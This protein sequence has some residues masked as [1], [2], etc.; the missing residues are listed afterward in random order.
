[1]AEKEQQQM[2]EDDHDCDGQHINTDAGDDRQTHAAAGT[3]AAQ[4]RF[5]DDAE[6]EKRH[7]ADKCICHLEE[8]FIAGIDEI[9]ESLSFTADGRRCQTDDNSQEDDLDGIGIEERCHDIIR[10][11]THEGICEGQLYTGLCQINRLQV[12]TSEIIRLDQFHQG[13]ADD[14]GTDSRKCIK[15][16]GLAADPAQLGGIPEADNGTGNGEEHQR[17]DQHVEAV[18]EQRLAG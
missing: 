3:A 8:H 14:S 4:K 11:D 12:E 15:G 10:N 13:K 16:H 7:K 18:H 6:N 5:A 2:I 9:L 1:M 17:R